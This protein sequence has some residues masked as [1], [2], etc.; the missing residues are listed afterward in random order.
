MRPTRIALCAA[1]F[2]LHLSGVAAAQVDR[3]ERG[4]DAERM[5]LGPDVERTVGKPASGPISGP[6]LD[7]LTQS[8]AKRMRC[9]V[10]QGA[11][12]ADSPSESARNM[13]QQVRSMIAAGY[14][15]DQIFR[16]FETSYGEFIRLVP[17]AEGINLLVWAIPLSGLLVGL[18]L[19]SG[20]WTRRKWIAEQ[21]VA[22]ES[23]AVSEP[24][25]AQPSN[26]QQRLLDAFR[27]EA[28]SDDA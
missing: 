24:G 20:F 1:L 12:V 18:A 8:M 11:A 4:T 5:A 13:K 17:R 6:A 22:R 7:Q 15:E 2:A 25:R 3:G 26:D 28:E 14:S 27:K 9:P 19:A 23:S 21:K 10:C 16:Y